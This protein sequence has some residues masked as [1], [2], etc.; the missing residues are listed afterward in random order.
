MIPF[1]RK[2]RKKMADNNRP[3]KY[4][5]YAIGEIVLVVIGILIAL[6]INNWNEERTR[7]AD[8]KIYLGN[9]IQDL[10]F[11]I[12]ILTNH[13]N[14]HNWR[15]HS[16]QHVLVLSG[17]K[18]TRN[19]YSLEPPNIEGQSIWK[20]W[21]GNIP[22]RYDSTFVK[23]ALQFANNMSTIQPNLSTISELKNNGL[24]SYLKDKELKSSIENYYRE[25]ERRFGNLEIGNTRK[26]YND[27]INSL[28]KNG[29]NTENLSQ[30]KEVLNWLAQDPESSARFRNL[31]FNAEW[32]Y[33]S[34]DTL[35][36]EAQELIS[37]IKG[38]INSD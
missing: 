17:Q 23:T 12:N 31:I 14:F 25:Y 5:R 11:D 26:F 24:Y 37:I 38:E 18:A 27:W 35:S 2:I 13:G 30:P 1:F 29:L 4:M 6:Q 32:R 21:T 8:L 3:L 15:Y 16:L 33:V 10:E 20:F 22:K 9:L 34:A 19:G 7:Q 36:Y 28:T